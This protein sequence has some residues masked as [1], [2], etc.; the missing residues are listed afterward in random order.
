MKILFTGGGTGGHFYPIIATAEAIYQLS[1]EERLIEPKLVFMSDS[2]YDSELLRIENIVYKKIYAGKIRRYFSLLNITDFFKT[3]IGVFKA[4]AMVYSEMPDVVFGKGGYASFPVILAA[5]IFR[6]PVV[7]HESDTIPGK[8]NK[9]AGKFAKSIAISFNEAAKFFP[10]EK[11][12]LTGTPVRKTIL[13]TNPEQAREILNMETGTPT[14]LVLGGSQGAQKINNILVDISSELVK[15]FQII[16]QCGV[17]NEQET[18]SRLGVVL[19]KSEFKNRYRLYPYLD[20]SKLKSA[21]SVADIVISRAGGSAIY[22]ISAWGLPS[23]VI[24]I[25]NSAQNHQRENAYSFSKAGACEVIEETNLSPNVLLSEINRIFSDKKKLTEMSKAA[26]GFAKPDAARKIAQ[27][28]IN[29]A[30]EHSK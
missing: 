14:I 20:D 16:H 12:A 6:I 1:E 5:R 4:M 7:I 23:I 18:K 10:K 21:A 26:S 15:N 25:K 8:V 2:P 30:L 19:N 29:I 28:I 27:Q 3:I 17:K 24:P 9:W 11:V 13:K 22:E